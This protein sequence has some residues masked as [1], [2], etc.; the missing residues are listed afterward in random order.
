MASETQK[1]LESPPRI[2]RFWERVRAARAERRGRGRETDVVMEDERGVRRAL[3]LLTHNRDLL[4]ARLRALRS[5]ASLKHSLRISTPEGYG[6]LDAFGIGRDEL[7][8]GVAGNAAPADAPVSFPHIWGMEYTG[9]LQWGAN[10]DSVMERNIGQALGVGAL[11]DPATFDSTV[12]IPNLHKLERFAYKLRPPAWPA[13]FPP[14]DTAKAGRGKELFVEHCAPCHETYKTDGVMRTYQLFAFAQT[15]TDPLA[16]INFELPVAQADG[17]VR[18]FPYAAVDL[19]SQIKSKAYRDAGYDAAT[20]DRLENRQ[21]RRGPEWNPAFRA[22]LLDASSYADTAGRKVYRAKTLVGIWATGPFLHNGS[23][24]TIYDLLHPAIARPATFPL[25]T[26]EYDP[27]RLGVQIDP[28]KYALA[29]DQDPFTFDTRLPGNWN[30]GHEW[31]FYP[32]LDDDA[33]Y[34][35][36]E[37]LKTFTSE[38]V[39][40]INPPALHAGATDAGADIPAAVPPAVRQPPLSGRTRAAIAIVIA[41][42]GMA[43]VYFINGVMPHGEAARATEAEDVAALTRGILALQQRFAAQ[44]NRPLARGTHAK[45]ICVRGVFEVFDLHDQVPDRLLAGRLAHGVFAQPGVYPAVIRFANADSHIYSDRKKD[46]RACSFSIDVP[47]GIAGRY[48]QRL[49]FSMNNAPTFPIND[50]H[51]FAVT[52]SVVSAP[53]MW[54]GLRTLTLKDKLGFLRTAALGA[55]QE[56]PGATAFQLMSYWSTVP[57]HHGPADVVKYAAVPCAGNYAEPI[58]AGPNCLQNELVRH[59]THDV[60]MSCFDFGLQLLDVETM[61]YWG[62]RRSASFWIENASVKWK[63][64]QAPFHVVARLTLVRDS[65]LAPD[66]CAAM[67]IDV[68]A[69]SAPDCKPLGGINRARPVAEAASRNA[70]L[71]AAAASSAAATVS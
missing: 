66:V 50:A 12:N 56:R 34:A 31:S 60:Q 4:D 17:T 57:F 42:A 22:P 15:G 37:F 24:P 11:F 65:V 51:A 55:F 18:P 44:Q 1:T 7:F 28:A 5:V 8:G 3:D 69:N 29:P 62:R 46:V 49:D 30:T 64:P 68:S 54:K 2:I 45:G 20:I 67:W 26:R 61:R 10:T 41:L 43:I 19:I 16:A 33:R 63:E 23:V 32:S 36:I 70:R 6:R 14:I 53:T 58:G 39:L 13:T 27:V 38:S 40:G 48:A 52:T 71:G 25:G 21:V 59:L 9:W 35:I 47:P